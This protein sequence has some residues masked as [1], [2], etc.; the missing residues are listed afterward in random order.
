MQKEKK[1]VGSFVF[2]VLTGSFDCAH[3]QRPRMGVLSTSDLPPHSTSPHFE[4]GDYGTLRP[5][6]FGCDCSSSLFPCIVEEVELMFPV[7]A[8]RMYFFLKP[9]CGIHL[10]TSTTPRRRLLMALGL[11]DPELRYQISTLSLIACR[12]LQPLLPV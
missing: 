2:V 1:L 6:W 10:G 11:G 8:S 3:L 9:F 5:R 7:L 4:V 12:E